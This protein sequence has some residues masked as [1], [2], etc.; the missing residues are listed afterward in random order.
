M[1]RIPPESARRPLLAP[2]RLLERDEPAPTV[3]DCR[4]R[5]GSPGEGERL[6][7]EAHLPGAAHLD[8]D[9]DLSA[10]PGEGGRHPLPDAES[11]QAAARR[12][13]VRDDRRVVAY[14]DA[15]S[16]GAAARL[17]WLLRHFGHADAWVLDGGIDAWRAAGGRLTS[18]PERS[19]PGDFTARPREDDVAS[20]QELLA[21]GLTPLDARAGERFRGEVE[22]I[23]P[24]AGHIPG[25]SSIPSAEIAPD[26]RFL[27][28]D[29]LRRRLETPTEA[30]A[31]CGS[32]ISACTL[33][34]AAEAAG[35]P[36]PRLYPGSWSEWST[37]GLP[38]ERQ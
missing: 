27:P 10:P 22:P 23:D 15:A 38:V 34:L 24:V 2:A 36:A 13:N 4:W 32:G 12:A 35:L 17:W 8:V 20:A 29:E 19:A 21:G 25:A 1:G 14:D 37:R 6:W 16:S 5:L 26:G 3:V 11:F 9:S 33:V 18:G 7:I 31:Y 30:V 28:A